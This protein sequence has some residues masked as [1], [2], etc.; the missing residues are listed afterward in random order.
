[1]MFLVN[2]LWYNSLSKLPCHFPYVVV[3]FLI[4]LSQ[5]ETDEKKHGGELVADVLKV[6]QTIHAKNMN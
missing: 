1:M 6:S 4:N 2:L 5:V 3:T